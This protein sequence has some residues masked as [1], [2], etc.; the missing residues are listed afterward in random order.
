MDAVKPI[1]L[2]LRFLLEICAVVAVGYSGFH[3]GHG[4]LTKLV[5]GLGG[6]VLVIVLWGAF[7]APKV[8]V[9]LPEPVRFALGL[10]ILL[11]AAIALVDAG[12]SVLGIVFGIV[13]IVNDL[14]LATW[15]Q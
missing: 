12:Q 3:T 14:L 1:N 6:P 10:V 8:A 5:L 2:A 13:I 9:S 4:T 11:A 15:H 7:A